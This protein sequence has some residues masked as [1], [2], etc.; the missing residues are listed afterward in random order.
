MPAA[1]AKLF[2]AALVA[3]L[4]STAALANQSGTVLGPFLPTTT[5]AVAAAQNGA[6]NIC[7]SYGGL[8]SFTVIRIVQNAGYYAAY[9]TYV[10]NN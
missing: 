4:P 5:A 8:Q 10:C 6:E 7:A 1:K 2:A 9:F 3:G